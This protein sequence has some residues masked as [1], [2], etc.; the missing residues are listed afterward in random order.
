MGG[1]GGG[2]GGS[3]KGGKGSGDGQGADGSN[4]GDGANGGGGA[5][6][7][8]GTGGN[9]SGC[10][11]HHPGSDNG[12]I[13]KGDPV[14]VV[15][16]R[17]Y[18]PLA[19]D[20]ALPGPFPLHVTRGYSSTA[21][22]RDLGLGHG[23]TWSLAWQLSEG[24]R[25]VRVFSHDGVVHTFGK[26]D[27]ETAMLG[28]HGWLL[29]LEDEGFRLEMPT[30][31]LLRFEQKAANT[32]TWLLTAIEDQAGNSV[33]LTYERDLLVRVDDAVGRV[34]QVGRGGSGHV[35][36]LA[37]V[38]D[39][40]SSH[41]FAR[42]H[43]DV[44]GN[45]IAVDD[46][47]G[48]RTHYRYDDEHR[49]SSYTDA[50]GLTFHFVYD[51]IGRC[52]ETWGDYPT[53]EDIGLW[54]DAPSQLADG[55]PAKGIFHTCM[56]YGD[57]GYSEAVDSVSVQRYFGNA[58]GQVEKAVSPR[59]VFERQ[60]DEHGYLVAFTDAL[61]ATTTW[62]RDLFGRELSR[63]DALGTTTQIERDQQGQITSVWDQRGGQTLVA[64]GKDTVTWTDAMGATT[65]VRF[66]ERGQPVSSL[67]P[68]GRTIELERDAHGNVVRSKNADGAVTQSRFDALGRCVEILDGRGGKSLFSYS[69]GGQLLAEVRPDGS[70]VSHSYDGVGNLTSR[71]DSDGHTT[72][73]FYGCNHKLAR[74]EKPNGEVVR[75]HYNR[76]G[77]L[78]QVINGRGKEHLLERDASGMVVK[79]TMFDGRTLRYGY[80]AMARVIWSE[81]GLRE[82]TEYTRDANGALVGV[83]YADGL[84]E[85]LLRDELG[86]VTSATNDAGTFSFQRNPMGWI[87]QEIQSVDGET[88]SVDTAYRI[89]GEV[90]ART[91][92]VGHR[93]N[94]AY[95]YDQQRVTLSLDGEVHATSQM[96]ALGQEVARELAGGGTIRRSFDQI[97]R[98]AEHAAFA[99]GATTAAAGQPDWVGS[100]GAGASYAA[101][102]GYTPSGLLAEEQIAGG[103]VRGYRYDGCAQLEQMTRDGVAAQSLT[104]D[105]NG[106]AFVEALAAAQGYTAGD[107]LEQVGD[108]RYAWDEDGRLVDK[109]VGRADDEEV[110]R[111]A[112]STS[113]M[114]SRVELPDGRVVTFAYDPFAR[115]VKKQ[116]ARR[117]GAGR[118]VL[119][120]TTR[121][122]WDGKTLVHEIKKGPAQQSDKVRTY[123]F[124]HG[125]SAPFAHRDD[126]DDDGVWWHY[127]NDDSGSPDALVGHDGKVGCR[128]ERTIWGRL[129]ADGP[130]DTDTPIRFRGQYADEE[131]GL[132]Y[133]R[134]RYFDPAVGR[135]ISADPIG[136]TG[137]LNVF[138]YANNCSTSAVDVEGL[139]FSI[140][141]DGDGNVVATGHNQKEHGGVGDSAH[142]AVPGRGSCAETTALNNLAT[143]M[144]PA[145]TKEDIAQ[146]F[147]EDGFTIETYEGN[148]GDY[149][150]GVRIPANPCKHC[151]KMFGAMGI[152]SDQ[153]R[154]HKQGNKSRSTTWNGKAVYEPIGKGT[155]YEARKKKR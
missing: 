59:G 81:N 98:V 153:V 102:F 6:G 105:K 66:D 14:D 24:R 60:F 20:L 136:I 108:T 16:G 1:G 27:A 113:G 115:R 120:S 8:C 148:E 134:H 106:N 10:A 125:W 65:T 43:Y 145:T 23:W 133:N 144:G 35:S 58:A 77:W 42:Y 112:W 142:S 22:Q 11:N 128:F 74:I 93:A 48:A 9:A 143:D 92:S 87:T 63:T 150:S 116:V 82:R 53:G 41:M 73:F 103:E 152:N 18:T 139:M 30:G 2:G 76:E 135:Y 25:S 121:Y 13:S 141:K 51:A 99:R 4:G 12:Q 94:W 117:D 46:A 84:E 104:Y 68:D 127:L 54:S 26:V 109:R 38:A 72:G 101:R 47:D 100:L 124:E 55:T 40:G 28:E 114:L 83:A 118:L 45:L 57:D 126:D 111:Y 7:A 137:G 31:Q 96:D 146:K 17:V 90:E 80:D 123:V 49:L 44:A 138:A 37:V 140:I 71:T 107:R 122:V 155:M 19:T 39:N 130:N 91:T 21:S 132:S 79:E 3:G 119:V 62:Q 64:R 29:Y 56:K 5:A 131:T 95:D 34:V 70:Q 89:T 61:G 129:P 36:S 147:N 97:G 151:K 78:M 15:T 69:A 67:W 85:T 33:S 154:G 75:I 149:D 110:T 52:V 88:V 50:V 86:D 32:E